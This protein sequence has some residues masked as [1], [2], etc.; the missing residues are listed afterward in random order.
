MIESSPKTNIEHEEN[1][2]TTQELIL[3]NSNDSD[4][5]AQPV[6]MM[7]DIKLQLTNES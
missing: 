2:P 4:G 5:S 3:K 1:S 6:K 7:P